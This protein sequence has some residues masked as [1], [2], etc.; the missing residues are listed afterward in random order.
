MAGGVTGQ[1]VMADSC[2]M[3]NIMPYQPV[4]EEHRA[5]Q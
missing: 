3:R 5:K 1:C 2:V 4:V